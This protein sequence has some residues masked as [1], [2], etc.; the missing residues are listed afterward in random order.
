MMTSKFGWAVWKTQAASEHDFSKYKVIAVVLAAG[1]GAA[2]CSTNNLLSG[3]GI[4]APATTVATAT[5]APPPVSAPLPVKLPAV[6][7]APVI[8]APK[9][10]SG[11]LMTSLKAAMAASKIP[12]VEKGAEAA[13]KLRGYMAA[14]PPKS[15]SQMKVAYIWDVMDK[16]KKRVHRIKGHEVV[17]FKNAKKPWSNVSSGVIQA[18]ATKT[19]TQLAQWLPKQVSTPVA[20]ARAQTPVRKVQAAALGSAAPTTTAA[21]PLTAQKSGTQQSSGSAGP[22]YAMVPTVVGAPGDGS[23]SLSEALKRQLARKGIKVTSQ[24]NANTYLVQG[25]V[26]LGSPVGG[27]QSIAIDWDVLSPSGKKIGTVSQKNRIPAGSLDG[28]WGKVADAAAEGAA[29]G[30]IKMLPRS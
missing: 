21:L 28:P 15:G 20:V 12:L 13:Y 9:T 4:D 30:I 26:K 25:R 19:V 18:I 14:I 1:L 27:R 22:I 17:P 10:I 6:A 8:G 5:Q 3:L 7:L 11:P 2:G 16:A 23:K 24:K 29:G